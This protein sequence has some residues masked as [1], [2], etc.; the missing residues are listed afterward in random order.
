[1]LKNHVYDLIA[2]MAEENKSLWR[3][4]TMYKTDSDV[5]D[6]CMNFWNELEKEK[7]A[8]IDKLEKLL[9]NHFKK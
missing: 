3:I 9:K 8:V 2:Q 7:E 4:K 6:E 5:C 1:M